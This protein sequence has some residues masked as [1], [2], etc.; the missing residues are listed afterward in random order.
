MRRRATARL[1]ATT[2]T[3]RSF[4]DPR[5]FVDDIVVVGF[6]EGATTRLTAPYEAVYVCVN[7]GN[8]V[9]SATNKTT[10]VGQLDDERRLPGG[11]ERQGA[12]GRC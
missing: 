4:S 3:G 6:S 10:L 12:R 8:N 9:P 2:S 11:E 7:G 5:V 1:Q